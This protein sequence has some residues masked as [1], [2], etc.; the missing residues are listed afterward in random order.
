MSD[1][2]Q[3]RLRQLHEDGGGQLDL[4]IIDLTDMPTIEAMAGAGNAVA[5]RIVSAVGDAVA[6]IKGCTRAKPGLCAAC[7]RPLRSHPYRIVLAHPAALD[8]EPEVC[9]M[10]VCTRCAPD[11]ATVL[12][13][14]G[15]VLR[16]L[17]PEARATRATG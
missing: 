2:W 17:Y 6:A 9:T 8:T 7:N 5:A 4:T 12:R 13:R 15:Q 3:A 1:T 10:A 14:A 16:L 11:R